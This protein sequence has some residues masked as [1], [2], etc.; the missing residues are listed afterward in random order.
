MLK[1]KDFCRI[2]EDLV[3]VEIDN[4]EVGKINKKDSQIVVNMINKLSPVV[5]EIKE[6]LSTLS[7][8][9][10][11][12]DNVIHHLTEKDDLQ[13]FSNFLKERLDLK[14]ISS[15]TDVQSTFSQDKTGLTYN[16]INTLMRLAWVGTSAAVGA[17]EVA[18]ALFIKGGSRPKGSGD[19]EIDSKKYEVK[20]AGAHFKGNRVQVG[21]PREIRHAFFIAFDSRLRKNA[22]MMSDPNLTK[23]LRFK[24]GPESYGQ[25][26]NLFWNIYRDESKEWGI[27]VVSKVILSHDKLEY[28]DVVDCIVSGLRTWMPQ[29]K[30]AVF[31][32][33]V[34]KYLQKD[35]SIKNKESFVNELGAI[36][37]DLYHQLESHE[38]IVFL[39]GSSK[40]NFKIIQFMEPSS[41]NSA[42]KSG[43]FKVSSPSFSDGSGQG[44]TCGF[45]IK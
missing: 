41:I 18:T 36:S 45:T 12:V 27:E 29:I 19:V 26:T 30:W 4:E 34:K 2:F 44:I 1:F 25:K 43:S 6:T 16:T 14:T 23:S 42:I 11:D 32:E 13:K 39:D 24:S 33:L 22:D 40:N 8:T 37:Y 35:G 15:R 17:G 7:F 38:G 9:P 10:K 3:P 21:A 5:D 31:Q 28:N 20:A